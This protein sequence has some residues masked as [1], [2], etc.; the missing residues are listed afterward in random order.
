MSGASGSLSN[1]SPVARAVMAFDDH[2]AE[3][4][5]NAEQLSAR[6]NQRAI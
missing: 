6:V 1:R 3:R 5:E 4:V 2:D